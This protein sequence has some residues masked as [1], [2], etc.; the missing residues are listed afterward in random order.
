[1]HNWKDKFLKLPSSIVFFLGYVLGLVLW[2]LDIYLYVPVTNFFYY[3]LEFI[4]LFFFTVFYIL[5]TIYSLHYKGN[6]FYFGLI[7]FITAFFLVLLPFFGFY[8]PIYQ[9]A[10]WGNT[11]TSETFYLGCFLLVIGGFFL[12]AD[13]FTQNHIIVINPYKLPEKTKINMMNAFLFV[14][15][16][17]F[18][19]NLWDYNGLIMPIYFNYAY[20]PE[21]LL[22]QK[23]PVLIQFLINSTLIGIWLTIFIYYLKRQDILKEK[24]VRINLILIF[25]L[26]AISIFF[27]FY[28]KNL[29]LSYELLRRVISPIP[30]F[31]IVPLLLLIVRIDYRAIK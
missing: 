31:F 22:L 5:I 8:L 1:M 2:P 18:V 16:L 6:T 11:L 14:A 3:I 10:P 28:C 17:F 7:I 24:F 23:V 29:N 13:I 27:I 4:F 19:Y 21:P 20:A 15:G 12:N 26:I 9:F 25:S 30:A